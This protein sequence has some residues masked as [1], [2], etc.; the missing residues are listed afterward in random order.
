M[1]Q[2]KKS[3]LK[4]TTKKS[5]AKKANQKPI[6]V[7][8]LN[9]KE[10]NKKN[11][12]I[13]I[14][15][16]IDEK[17]WA[18]KQKK[19][20]TRIQSKL[21]VKGFRKGKVPLEKAKS[22]ISDS[23]CWEGAVQ[24]LLDEAVK[25]AAKEIKEEDL[26]L[27]S[28]TYKV[29]KISNK[30]C[31]IIF[32]YPTFVDLNLKKYKNFGIKHKL[33][34]SKEID[35]DVAK[36]IENYASKNSLWLPKEDKN[37]KVEE[38]DKIIFDFVGKVDGKEFEGGEDEDFELIIG[39]KQFIPGFEENLVGIPKDK[40]SKIDVS[41]PKDYHSKVLAGKKAVFEVLVKEIKYKEK[42]EINDELVKSLN[43]NKIDNLKDLKIYLKD[44]TKREN[45]EKQRT[46]FITEFMKKIIKENKFDVP[47]SLVLKEFQRMVKSFE[48]NIKNYGVDKKTYLKMMGKDEAEFTKELLD[49][50]EDGVKEY[51]VFLK[52]T[53]E[54]KIEPKEKDY[55][56]FY[57]LLSKQQNG[58][59]IDQLKKTYPKERIKSS[60]IN[61]LFID[62]LIKNN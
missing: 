6:V 22:L 3:T 16:K 32:V 39:S 46:K 5:S 2:T 19:E 58:L 15:I 20:F 8:K 36:Q 34:T 13:E 17:I 38:G 61:N 26:I 62:F 60:I 44:L 35:N 43:I 12:E 55:E 27:D 54:E 18:A 40:T 47:K 28:P 7:G 51:F 14:I 37:A 42:S 53:R 29:E 11:Q 21:D 45:E 52:I 48:D 9:K 33:M 30:E 41:F 4:N 25:I 24:S 49:Q 10:I 57:K 31:E 56:D 23:D 1:S 59:E 50:A